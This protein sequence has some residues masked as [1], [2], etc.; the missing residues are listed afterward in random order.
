MGRTAGRSILRG[1]AAVK[2]GG[3]DRVVGAECPNGVR[4]TGAP[5]FRA[6]SQSQRLL[7]GSRGWNVAG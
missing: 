2:G 1:G 4:A 5:V 7:V 3:A 6:R